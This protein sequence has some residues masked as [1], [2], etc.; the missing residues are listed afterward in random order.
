MCSLYIDVAPGDDDSTAGTEKEWE[1]CLDAVENFDTILI[2]LR[3][4]GFTFI[5]ALIGSEVFFGL[6][7]GIQN[8]ILL[9]ISTFTVVIYWLDLYY[10]NALSGTLLRSIFLEMFHLE[11]GMTYYT[12]SIYAKTKS[13]YYI[14]LLYG[15]LFATAIFIAATVN[16]PEPLAQST[17][18]TTELGTKSRQ[19]AADSKEIA[20]RPF[21][22][23]KNL[24]Q[25][26][27]NLTQIAGNSSEIV[28]NS[29]N[30]LR[31]VQIN[32][33]KLSS[34]DFGD[35]AQDLYVI[36]TSTFVV[37]ILMVGVSFILTMY[38]T[39]R[40]R[41]RTFSQMMKVYDYC[42][43]LF[44]ESGM[45]STAKDIGHIVMKLLQ[46]K[47]RR[48]YLFSLPVGHS[49][50]KDYTLQF[51]G[52][53]FKTITI[54]KGELGTLLLAERKL[55]K[56]SRQKSSP[57]H[58]WVL[59]SEIGILMQNTIG[60]MDRPFRKE[61]FHFPEYDN[62]KLLRNQL[63]DRKISPGYSRLIEQIYNE[64]VN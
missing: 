13:E 33:D 55:K 5:S 43:T 51:K 17:D 15:G 39:S 3:K 1:K 48:R 22:L 9:T 19:L 25:I 2:D 56:F 46:E 7:L 20:A 64:Y 31:N 32:S 50:E 34:K 57:I 27:G 6:G 26:A 47:Q 60:T 21:G 63:E 18:N 12:S 53:K 28:G 16:T 37:A 42:H 38:L 10:R 29:T 62:E 41:R 54:N 44:H 52:G 24:T 61:A 30:I 11:G 35:I 49:D 40:K 8:A 59:I 23:A 14:V 58:Y 36:L 45:P 4:Y